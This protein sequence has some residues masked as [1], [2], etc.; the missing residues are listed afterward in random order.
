ML[1]C[2][3]LFAQKLLYS[4]LSSP[5]LEGVD[6]KYCQSPFDSAPLGSGVPLIT[7]ATQCEFSAFRAITAVQD[8]RAIHRL[9]PDLREIGKPLI[10]APSRPTPYV[11]AKTSKAQALNSTV[12]IKGSPI[13]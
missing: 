13:F 9:P 5:H 4:P 3:R 10:S 6:A 8:L 7:V 12:G 11:N 2:G 1:C